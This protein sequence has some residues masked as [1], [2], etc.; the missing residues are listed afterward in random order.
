MWITKSVIDDYNGT[1]RLT[2]IRPGFQVNI[3][4]PAS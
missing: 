2:K 1:I 3:N 4:L